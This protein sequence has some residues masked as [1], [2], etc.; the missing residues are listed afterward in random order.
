HLRSETDIRASDLLEGEYR[1]LDG[2]IFRFRLK[3]RL[4]SHIFQFVSQDHLRRQG[5]DG[6]SRHFADIGNGTAGPRIYLDHIN[7]FAADDKL[8]VDHSDHMKGFRKAAGVLRYRLFRLIADG[9]GRIY[10]NTVSGMDSSTL[11]VLHDSG[12]QDIFSVADSVHLDLFSHKVFVHKDRMLLGDLVDNADIFVHLLVAHRDP[13]ALAAKHVGRTYQDRISQIVGRLL[14]LLGGKYRVSLGSG[15]LALFKDAVEELSV[16][17]RV[18][19]LS[20]CSHDLNAH[21]HKGFCQLN[22]GLSSEL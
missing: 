14:R 5:H 8:N 11:D 7:L 19:I 18:H 2:N 15:D 10:G 4:I 12:D 13:Q 16:L 17:C 20:G 21:F 1:H 3:S 9:S 6:D 22:S